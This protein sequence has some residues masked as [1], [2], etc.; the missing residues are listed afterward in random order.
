MEAV[1]ASSQQALGE[2][3]AEGGF[4][5]VDS[6]EQ[7]LLVTLAES[8]VQHLSPLSIVEDL[9]QVLLSLAHLPV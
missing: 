5:L 8:L 2:R 9:E 6:F 1:Y 7:G 4:T 3:A